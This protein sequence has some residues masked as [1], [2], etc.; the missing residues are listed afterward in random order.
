MFS[1]KNKI[2]TALIILAISMSGY[3][4]YKYYSYVQKVS[5]QRLEISKLN[6]SIDKLNT[7]KE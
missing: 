5:E 1:I 2:N 7:M 4:L 6:S 3:M